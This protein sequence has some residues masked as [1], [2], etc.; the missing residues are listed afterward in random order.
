[1]TDQFTEKQINRLRVEF[2]M[3]N[4]IDPCLPT[5][6]KMIALLDGMS[7]AQLRQV[8]YANIR[9]LSKLAANRLPQQVAA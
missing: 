5:Y 1:M 2:A 8:Q 6:P 4:R 7:Q 3:I 9:F